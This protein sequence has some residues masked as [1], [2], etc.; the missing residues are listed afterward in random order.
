V[1]SIIELKEAVFWMADDHGLTEYKLSRFKWVVQ[2][3]QR[4][5]TKPLEVYTH[6]LWAMND[7]IFGHFFHFI[8]SGDYYIVHCSPN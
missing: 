4:V 8:D 3:I 6:A 5:V 7:V 2:D 1:R